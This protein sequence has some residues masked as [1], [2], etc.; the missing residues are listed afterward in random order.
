LELVSRPCSSEDGLINEYGA[1]ERGRIFKGDRNIRRNTIPVPFCPPQIPHDLT[2]ARNLIAAIGSW[3]LAGFLLSLLFV[4]EDE[5][6]MFVE[7]IGR[8]SQDYTALYPKC[9]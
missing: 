4:L 3:H 9:S 5:G 7:H 1:V 6:D 8:L 2:W